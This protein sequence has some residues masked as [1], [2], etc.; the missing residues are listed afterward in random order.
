MAH[1]LKAMGHYYYYFTFLLRLKLAL[2]HFTVN[3]VRSQKYSIYFGR[4]GVWRVV[5]RSAK[6]RQPDTRKGSLWVKPERTKM[7]N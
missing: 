3:G 7:S 1:F 6:P 2:I 4:N 5:T